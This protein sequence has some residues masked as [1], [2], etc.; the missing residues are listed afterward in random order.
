MEGPIFGGLI[1][2]GKFAFQNRLSLYLEGNL[3]LKIDWVSL[4]L[5]RRFT[6]FLCF[7][8]YSRRISKYKLEF[9]GLIFEGLIFGILRYMTY[10]LIKFRN[11]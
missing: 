7:T 9:G 4:I 5:G 11:V 10:G 8:L 6:V 3:R 2:G 1:Y